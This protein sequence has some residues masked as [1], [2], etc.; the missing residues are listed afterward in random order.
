MEILYYYGLYD[1]FNPFGRQAGNIHLISFL[2]IHILRLKNFMQEETK[3]C[4]KTFASGFCFIIGKYI[5]IEG[6]LNEF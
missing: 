1:S 5:R 4:A 6:W 3:L 2:K